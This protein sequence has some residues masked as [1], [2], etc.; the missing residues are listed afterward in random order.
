MTPTG[1]PSGSD[2]SSMH[3][4]MGIKRS[5]IVGGGGELVSG[6]GRSSFGVYWFKYS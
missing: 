3:A 6:F 4:Q 1:G 2:V 5:V